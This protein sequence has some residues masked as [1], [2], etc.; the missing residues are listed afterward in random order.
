MASG[1]IFQSILA[2]LFSGGDDNA[3]QRKML[4][5]IAKNLSKTKYHFYKPSSHEVDPTF[6]KFF[7]EIYK[8]VSPAQLMFANTN[9]NSL[10]RI[11]IDLSLS[12]EQKKL[13]E[14]LSEEELNKRGANVPLQQL[15]EETKGQLEKFNSE[16]TNDK[17]LKTDNLYTKLLLF[18]NFTQYDFFF[19]LK[20]FDSSMKE[21]NFNAA[22]KF[23]QI[24]GSYVVEDIKN[25]VSVAWPLPTDD[26]DDVFKLIKTLKGVEPITLSTWKKVLQRLRYI[27]EQGILEMMVQL[28]TD[29]PAYKEVIKGED[30]HILDEYISQTRKTVDDV[31]STLKERQ[32]AGKVD[33]LLSQLFGN[34][35]IEPLKNYNDTVSQTFLNKNLTG[36]LYA[37]PLSYLKHF[38]LNYVK[39]EVRELSDIL[40]IRGEWSSQSM[41]QPMS[42]SSH[43]LMELSSKI[44]TLDESLA[45]SG[46]YGNKLRTLMPRLDRDRETRNIMEMTLGDA[47]N[48]AAQIL[49]SAKQNIIIFDKNLKM[50]L[51]DFV[52]PNP[53]II[54]NWKD[55]DRFAEGKLKQMGVEVYKKLYNFISLLQNFNIAI[56]EAE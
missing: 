35:D 10:K 46:K 15:V 43:Q 26:W 6:A 24:A 11:V 32:T 36:L 44:T 7:Y 2:S 37:A 51:E 23:Q 17:I 20:K 9:P 49:G 14:A 8:A 42:E 30:Y 52:K 55:L 1:N 16:F 50:L 12:E 33:N 5:R 19:L 28:I 31:L 53:S 4:K 13:A 45:E 29:N 18:K 54:R 3:I 41:S 48:E 39:K 40:V 34:T 27:R 56:S 47:N 22:P 21:R 38:L 25:F